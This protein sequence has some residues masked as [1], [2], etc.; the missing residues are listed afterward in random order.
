MEKEPYQNQL[1]A[2]Q[3]IRNM[4]DNSLRFHHLSGKAGIVVGILAL[5][6]V[7][8]TYSLLGIEFS[9]PNYVQTIFRQDALSSLEQQILVLYILLLI[10][11]LWAGY[12]FARKNANRKG[13]TF[14]NPASVRLVKYMSI[15]LIT[16][17]ILCCIFI[18]HHQPSW[19]APATLLFYGLALINGS[20]HTLQDVFYLGLLEITTGLLAAF[21]INYGLLF[22]AFGMGILHIVYGFHLYRKYEK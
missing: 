5:I 19:L 8:V 4:M 1:D 15:P 3:Y 11:S 2:L 13:L 10:I 21:F 22:W 16:G 18:F 9:D 7:A 14:W 17:G 12:Y 6:A 20:K